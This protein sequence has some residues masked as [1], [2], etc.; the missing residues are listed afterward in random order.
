[1]AK[2]KSY[3]ARFL[4]KHKETL[5][6]LLDSS[7]NPQGGEGGKFKLVKSPKVKTYIPKRL[8]EKA[9]KRSLEQE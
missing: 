7:G 2:D 1:V 3:W 4:R 5:G 8:K 6:S 9:K